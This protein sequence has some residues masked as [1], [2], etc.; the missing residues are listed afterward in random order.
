MSFDE[1]L[2]HYVNGMVDSYSSELCDLVNIPSVSNDPTK[3]DDLQRIL[4]RVS[5]IVQPIGFVTQIVPTKGNPAMIATLKISDDKPWLMIYNHMDVQPANEPEWKTQ[6]F[7]ATITNGKII[8]RGST[9][10]KGPALSVIHAIKFLKDN[11]HDLPNIQLVYETEEEIGS[12]NFGSFIE[13]NLKIG[14]LMIP[15]SI[16]VSDT[17][18][19]GDS[20]SISY[21]LRGVVRA[22][23]TLQTADKEVHSGMAGGIAKN[24]LKILI[25]ALNSCYEENNILIPGWHDGIIPLTDKEKESTKKASTSLIIEKFKSDLG[26][27][28]THTDNS[29][30]AIMRLWHQP[31]FEVHGFEGA[32]HLPGSIKTAIPKSVTAKLTMRIVP[33]QDVDNLLF[34][35]GEHLRNTHPGI[36]V[37]GD[38]L[39]AS[40]TDINNPFV[41]R[42]EQAC[43]YGFGKEPLFVGC[44]GSIGAVT[45]FQRL[46]EG[47]PVVLIAQSLLSDGYHAPNEEFRLT[48]AQAGCKTMAK[49]ISSIALMR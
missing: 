29:Q 21:K 48:Q 20:P 36:I 44:G 30:E 12:P 22:F 23:V 18:F 28:E 8:G 41:K 34:L 10:D 24:P 38:G 27:L 13:E 31:T 35:L 4:L 9:D 2:D 42:A 6:A 47:V 7:T 39:P 33:G 3:K 32:Q 17:I 5:E 49:Y 16:L 11:N 37:R 1:K 40:I 26:L 43:L 14:K 45:E 19:E 15:S 25:K 46:L